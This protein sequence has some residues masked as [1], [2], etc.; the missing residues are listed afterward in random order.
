[1]EA[2]R[3]IAAMPVSSVET[4]RPASPPKIL[5]VQIKPAFAKNNPYSILSEM[6]TTRPFGASGG[7]RGNEK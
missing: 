3:S 2:V 4:G 6:S 7:E 5:K 1:M